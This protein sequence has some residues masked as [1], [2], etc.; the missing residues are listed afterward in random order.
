MTDLVKTDDVMKTSVS[1]DSSRRRA[2]TGAIAVLALL[3]G[4]V[5]GAAPV[6]AT[7]TSGPKTTVTSPI[8]AG[9]EGTPVGE[10]KLVRTH[11]EDE[12]VLFVEL[13]VGGGIEESHLCLD[14]EPFTRRVPPGQCQYQQG[15]TG[16][17]ARYLIDLPASYDGETVYV[18]AHVATAGET[19]YAGWTRP[20]R[21]GAF[22]GNVAVEDPAG[23]ETPVPVG[24][25][26]AL[27]LAGVV[28][29]GVALRR[30]F[31]R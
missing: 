21:G 13:K 10:A 6:A 18:Q 3:A 25:A 20:S 26:G 5:A 14:D 19:A 28:A 15:D 9:S 12:D 16:T 1:D 7:G 22:F 4:A 2:V 17:R 27:A 30:G 11:G 29:G 31:R 23:D 24:T 8:Q